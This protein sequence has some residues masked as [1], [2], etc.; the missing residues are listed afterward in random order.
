[1]FHFEQ[2]SSNSCCSTAVYNSAIV[3]MMWYFQVVLHLDTSSHQE[4]DPEMTVSAQLHRINVVFLYQFIAEIQVHYLVFW[5]TFP[6]QFPRFFLSCVQK[7]VDKL[8]ISKKA[9]KQAENTAKETATTTVS[10]CYCAY[11]SFTE[12]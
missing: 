6:S 5:V 10:W 2:I 12:V 8:E 9:V 1:M 11:F 4:T 7:F 3:I